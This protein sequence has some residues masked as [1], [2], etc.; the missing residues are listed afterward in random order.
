MKL[1]SV[2]VAV[3]CA[4]CSISSLHAESQVDDYLLEALR[5]VEDPDGHTNL[6]AKTSLDG[7]VLGRIVSGAVVSVESVQG[8]WAKLLPPPGTDLARYIHTS[9]LKP[10]KSWKE[11]PA[12]VEAEGA[13][14]TATAGGLTASVQKLPFDAA[15]N[16]I[17]KGGNG[18]VKVNGRVIQGTDGE[19]PTDSLALTVSVN[20]KAVSLP[21]AAVTDLFQPNPESLVL[22]TPPDGGSTVIVLMQNSDGAGSY[23]VAW[24]F[25]GATY[26]GR[27]LVG[28]P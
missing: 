15:R 10:L 21:A 28:A 17:E 13:K 22:L 20:G 11:S 16:K 26:T 18:E 5:V 9:R 3:V 7:G 8:D 2:P 27:A 24:S 23:G 4:V 14:A 19:A 6:R 1:L 25:N 12:K